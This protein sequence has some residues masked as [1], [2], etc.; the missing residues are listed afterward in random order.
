MYGRTLPG[1][2]MQWIKAVAVSVGAESIGLTDGWK[3]FQGFNSKHL[4]EAARQWPTTK[5]LL[6][7]AE[8]TNPNQ[9]N[10]S[11]PEY[12]EKYM[13]RIRKG[14]YYGQFGF[15]NESVDVQDLI[16]VNAPFVDACM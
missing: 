8:R 4:Q 15:V 5:Y 1:M 2:A 10:P 14:G 7:R 3:G 16:Y 12:T 13:E 6:R 11:S 9:N